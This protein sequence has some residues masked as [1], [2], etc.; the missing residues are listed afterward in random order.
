MPHT[1]TNSPNSP[2]PARPRLRDWLGLNASTLAL[3]GAIF[4]VTAGTELWSPLIPQF[5]KAKQ[6]EILSGGGAGLILVIGLYG[7]YRDA[8]E[9]INYYLGGAITGRF[10]TRRSLLLF[11]LLPLAGLAFL[12]ARPS[13]T[14]LLLVVPLLFCWDAIAGPATLTVVGDALPPDRRTMAFSLQAIFRRLSRMAAYGIS[15]LVVWHWGRTGGFRADLAIAVGLILLAAV[16]QL[17]FMRTVSRDAGVMIHRPREMLRS[18]DPNLKRLLVA[19]ICARWAEGIANHFII[20]FC[21]PILAADATLGTAKYQGILLNIQAATNIAMYLLVGPLASRAGL[22]KK[23]YIGLTFVF[24]ALF[25]LSLAVLGTSFGAVGLMA[26]FV[27]GGLREL[28]E[29]ARK[30]MVA[31][32]V[33][34]E[35]KSQAIGLYWSARS[36]AVMFASPVGALAWLTGDAVRPGLGPVVNFTLAGTIGLIGAAAFFMRF[37]RDSAADA[38]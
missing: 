10:N 20:L 21:V 2:P 16:V 24:F 27:V 26:A 29:P 23:P 36:V 28:G 12:L 17:R 13:P 35:V 11:N 8:L 15:A 1:T 4:L 34:A 38:Q 18:F 25:P 33:P 3:L 32:L 30:A 37:G 31:D 5:F 9:A 6:R 14:T 22:A 19:D 7:F